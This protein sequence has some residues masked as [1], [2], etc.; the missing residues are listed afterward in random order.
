M[1]NYAFLGWYS[2]LVCHLWNMDVKRKKK[3]TGLK[4]FETIGKVCWKKFFLILEIYPNHFGLFAVFLDMKRWS[5]S[6]WNGWNAN[7]TARYLH[8]GLKEN[9]ETNQLEERHH[10][11]RNRGNIN[12][13]AASLLD[14]DSKQFQNKRNCNIKV[15]LRHWRTMSQVI[16]VS[17]FKTKDS[18]S[19][20]CADESDPLHDE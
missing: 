5:F 11:S 16:T 14:L 3:E 6:C 10:L 12:R 8:F 9:D 18:R 13:F 20:F 7:R 1:E 17:S 19:N 4:T 15:A 2:Q